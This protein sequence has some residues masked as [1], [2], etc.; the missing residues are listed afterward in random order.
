VRLLH[1]TEEEGAHYTRVED[2]LK[3]SLDVREKF[4]RA[5]ER[6]RKYKEKARSFYK[7]LTFASWGRDAGFNAGYLE[8]D[9]CQM[10]RIWTP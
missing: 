2:L 10:V 1:S 9:E 6:L 3:S 4:R 7:Q 8:G 5:K